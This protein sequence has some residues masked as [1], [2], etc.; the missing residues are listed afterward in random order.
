MRKDVEGWLKPLWTKNKGSYMEDK[1]EK[2]EAK[3]RW[4]LEVTVLVSFGG[5]DFGS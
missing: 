2:N 4:F 3:K 1:K 5:L